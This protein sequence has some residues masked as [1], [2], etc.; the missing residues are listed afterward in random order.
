VGNPFDDVVKKA[1][2]AVKDAQKKAQ[3]AYE[4]S[5]RE[6]QA[7][8]QNPIGYLQTNVTKAAN[9]AATKAQKGDI[10]GAFQEIVKVG[11]PVGGALDAVLDH[12]V[13]PIKDAFLGTFGPQP[14]P[15]FTVPKIESPPDFYE[16]DG[17]I[18]TMKYNVH[19]QCTVVLDMSVATQVDIVE[20]AGRI[21][22]GS[23]VKEPGSFSVD[24]LEPWAKAVL[25][26]AQLLVELKLMA[27]QVLYNPDFARDDATPGSPLSRTTFKAFLSS[28]DDLKIPALS[29]AIA[30]VYTRPIQIFG[31]EKNSGRPGFYF[32]PFMPSKDRD[33]LDDLVDLIVA[34]YEA[35]LFASVI[36]SPML[37]INPNWIFTPKPIPYFSDYGE[38]LCLYYPVKVNDGGVTLY[39]IEFK[40][41]E[42]GYV[43][44][45]QMT[46]LSELYEASVFLRDTGGATD[47]G[48][49]TAADPAA[50]KM[51]LK[52]ME[53]S[54]TAG[55]A[56]SKASEV[57]DWLYNVSAYRSVNM[58]GPFG[59]N[60]APFMVYS[61][62]GEK[63]SDAWDRSL[64]AWMSKHIRSRK[65]RIQLVKGNLLPDMHASLAKKRDKMRVKETSQYARHLGV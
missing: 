6:M 8:F 44:W 36:K 9:K 21:V 58:C 48:F 64:S 5:A 12:A 38:W 37:P 53:F 4:R 20:D 61:S 18:T 42:P 46:G 10:L 54:D 62:S 39:D 40:A 55:T 14:M 63:D 50:D 25:G 41:A 27:I 32:I 35:P 19:G 28:V 31:A 51:S 24:Y 57:W 11:T 13:K 7:G 1:K 65:F 60:H 52:L 26:G 29:Y 34:E 2:K 30:E 43:K 15:A 59:E 56:V 33:D 45:S 16:G 49:V 47:P 17:L 3:K 22:L 23:L